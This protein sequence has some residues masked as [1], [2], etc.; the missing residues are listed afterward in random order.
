VTTEAST[1]AGLQETTIVGR[2]DQ[3]A[4]VGRTV[5]GALECGPTAVRLDASMFVKSLLR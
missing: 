5:I 1:A 3:W 4:D 2:H